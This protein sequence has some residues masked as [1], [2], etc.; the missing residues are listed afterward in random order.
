MRA[1]TLSMIKLK[2]FWVSTLQSARCDSCDH[3]CLFLYDLRFVCVVCLSRV[4]FSSSLNCMQQYDLFI[5]NRLVNVKNPSNRP[6]W[7]SRCFRERVYSDSI[8][9]AFPFSSHLSDFEVTDQPLT[10]VRPVFIC[11]SL[12]VERSPIGMCYIYIVSRSFFYLWLCVRV[13]LNSKFLFYFRILSV[14]RIS[15]STVRCNTA[16]NRCCNK[17]TN[18]F[19]PVFVFPISFFLLSHL[20]FVFVIHLHF[21]YD[22]TSLFFCLIFAPSAAA[23]VVL[24][25]LRF[26][27]F[28]KNDKMHWMLS[29]FVFVD[30][31][32]R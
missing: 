11:I 18:I 19:F 23:V 20:I 3:Q 17:K 7:F 27:E 2:D 29:V 12:C 31:F 25:F 26:A 13:L 22:T 9:F 10:C 5:G 14:E 30:N 16:E 28:N 4:F 1:Y 24:L 8:L 15:I 6:F 21:I 32:H